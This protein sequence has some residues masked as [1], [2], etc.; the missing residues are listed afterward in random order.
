MM[1]GNSQVDVD[2]GPARCEKVLVGGRAGHGGGRGGRSGRSA[3][4]VFHDVASPLLALLTCSLALASD[5]AGDLSFFLS[6]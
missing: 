1:L 2:G 6:H 4:E 5:H 3:E